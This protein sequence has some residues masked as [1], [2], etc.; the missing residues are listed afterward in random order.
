[1]QAIGNEDDENGRLRFVALPDGQGYDP[2]ESYVVTLSKQEERSSDS[3]ADYL[4]GLMA[5]SRGWAAPC[6]AIV[7][8]F[9]SW[10]LKLT[11]PLMRR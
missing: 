1:M 5:G 6:C 4:Q 8:S 7:D 3:I 11:A 10:A 9:L 2:N